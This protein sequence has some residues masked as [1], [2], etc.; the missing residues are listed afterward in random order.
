VPSRFSPNGP[1]GPVQKIEQRYLACSHH[2]RQAIYVKA[3]GIWQLGDM[4]KML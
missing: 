3:V 4:P 2:A 1:A